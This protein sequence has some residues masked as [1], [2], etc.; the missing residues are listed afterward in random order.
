[1]PRYL[2]IFTYQTPDQWA[3]AGA[4]PGTPDESSRALFIK[5]DNPE[6][7]LTWGS[8]I[9][10]AFVKCLFTDSTISWQRLNYDH[11]LEAQPEQEYPKDILAALPEVNYGQLPDLGSLKA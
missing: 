6:Q 8:E 9:A 2:Y 11:W 4:T 10:E 7:A 1:M 5:A 3:A